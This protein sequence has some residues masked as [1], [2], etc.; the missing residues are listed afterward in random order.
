MPLPYNA[1]LAVLCN[2]P[3][4]ILHFPFAPCLAPAICTAFHNKKLPHPGGCGSGAYFL[5]AES[6]ITAGDSGSLAAERRGGRVKV[7]DLVVVRG[8]VDDLGGDSPV[9][10]ILRP[11]GD[12]GGIREG[13]QLVFLDLFGL[14]QT[15]EHRGHFLTGDVVVRGERAVAHAVDDTAL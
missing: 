2:F 3:F 8:A 7:V 10:G 5:L 14:G 11:V 15:V 1:R 6:Q 13:G 12:G 9:H 4:S